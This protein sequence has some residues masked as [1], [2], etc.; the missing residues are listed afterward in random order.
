M[1]LKLKVII[2]HQSLE[3]KVVIIIKYIDNI[4]KAGQGVAIVPVPGLPLGGGGAWL[5]RGG[6]DRGARGLVLGAAGA[7]LNTRGQP[8][9][10]RAANEP[11]RSFT[12]PGEGPN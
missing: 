11:S 7:H 6:A 4:A 8:L 5:G 9:D 3:L 1:E 10:S 12:A 2:Y